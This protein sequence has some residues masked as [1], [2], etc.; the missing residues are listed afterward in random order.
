MNKTKI[1]GAFVFGVVLTMTVPALARFD[2]IDYNMISDGF[3]HLSQAMDRNA[4]A[5][6]AQTR[7]MLRQC[8]ASYIIAGKGDQMDRCSQ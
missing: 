7:V 2:W 6:E 8:E 1:L 4:N 5:T 3:N